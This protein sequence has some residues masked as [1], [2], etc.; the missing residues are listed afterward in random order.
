VTELKVTHD[1]GLLISGGDDGSIFIS[2]INAVSDGISVTDAELLSSFKTSY[3][4]YRS[5]YYMQN[6]L[7]TSTVIEN[8][9]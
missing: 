2:K 7:N 5:L 6:Y 8:D 4:N 9:Q 1:F 3:K